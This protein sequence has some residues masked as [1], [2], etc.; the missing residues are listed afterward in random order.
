MGFS[1]K[2]YPFASFK[3]LAAAFSLGSPMKACPFIRPSFIKRI[4][5]LE[6]K[7]RIRTYCLNT[8]IFHSTDTMLMRKV[9]MSKIEAVPTCRH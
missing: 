6:A 4:S 9:G 1:N 7:L 8:L 2:T 3:A 5:N